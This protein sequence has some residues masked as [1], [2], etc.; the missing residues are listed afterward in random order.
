M[1][2]KA[3]TS[4]REPSHVRPATR[5]S[6][7][8]MVSVMPTTRSPERPAEGTFGAFDSAAW[9]TPGIGIESRCAAT[10]LGAALPPEA[11]M[12]V[13]RD[14]A[15]AVMVRRERARRRELTWTPRRGFGS[16]GPGPR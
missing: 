2:T 10:G 1:R 4:I 6:C 14:V 7:V 12:T 8:A 9:S 3:S 5:K 11:G 13:T 16:D 15:R